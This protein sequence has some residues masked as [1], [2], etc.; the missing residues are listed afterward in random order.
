MPIERRTLLKLGAAASAAMALPTFAAPTP[1]AA[2]LL[3]RHA[4]V[5]TMDAKLGELTDADVL[6]R[7]GMIVA[8]GK[9]LPSDGAQIVDATGMILIPGLVDA[10]WHLW[11]S[12]LR[13]SAP[14]PQG[15][16]FFKAQ[17][18]T[19]KRFTPQL[20]A[21]GVRLGLAEAVN[22]GI[23]TVNNW[24]HNLRTPAF[25]QAEV[26]AM[27]ASGLRGRFWYGYAQ[28]LAATAPMDFADIERVQKQLQGLPAHR[29]DLG[30]AIRGPERTE[31]A[32][33]EPEFAFAKAHGLPISTHIAVTAQMQKKKAVQQLAQKG[34]LSPQVQLVHAT[35]VDA[36][37]IATIAHSRA[38]VC[39]TPLTEM[40][41]GYGLAP[42]DK[43][44]QA[45][46]PLSLGIDT[47]VL[48]GNANPFMVMQTSL[49]LATAISGNEQ[50]LT[51]KD[52]LHWA[53]QGGADAMGLGALIGSISPGKRADLA[54]I[55]GRRLGLLP[56]TD[57]YATVVQSATPADVDTVIA[58]GRLLKRGGR[59][60]Q[61]DGAALAA[62]T[63]QALKALTG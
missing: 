31:A 54:L 5:L 8:V 43:L 12:F 63:A 45:K 48:S 37:D 19:S 61:V 38:S 60:L 2:H 40:R 3:I 7:E 23:T 29:L 56:V 6:I 25:A 35:H 13:N 52:V 18:A 17:L 28:D 30:L 42:V 33:W 16:P 62:D 57:P 10:H 44:H 1:S 34:V 9:H 50:A 24:A 59:L 55:D 49:N 47:L 41:V 36:E 22:G 46:I 15:E 21:L 32:V 26:E 39:I 58:D 27:L 11:N 14:A 4:T 53:T 20:S 51:A